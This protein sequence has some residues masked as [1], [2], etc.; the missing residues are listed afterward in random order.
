ME[1]RNLPIETEG[2]YLTIFFARNK[3]PVGNVPPEMQLK[4]IYLSLCN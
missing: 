4:T 3:L 1:L 2:G